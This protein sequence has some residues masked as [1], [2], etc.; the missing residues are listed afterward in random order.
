MIHLELYKPLKFDHADQ[1]YMCKPEAVEETN[2]HKILWDFELKM[3]P[4][5]LVRRP[6]LV[7]INKM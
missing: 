6:A 7:V 2:T 1:W 3:Y 4:P 5:F